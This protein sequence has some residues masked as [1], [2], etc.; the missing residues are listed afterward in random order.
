MVHQINLDVPLS[1]A[2]LLS[3]D[4][5]GQ[6]TETHSISAGLDYPGVGP[7][8]SYLKDTGRATYVSVTDKQALEALQ[9]LSRMEGIIPALEPAH[10]IYH[11]MQMARSLPKEEIVLIHMCGRGD[12]DMLTVAGA[13]GFDVGSSGV[14][15][16]AATSD[17]SSSSGAGMAPAGSSCGGGE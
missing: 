15:A 11:G 13:L 2:L 12:K 3:Q 16:A 6:I 17:G 5:N 7:Q 1:S 10:A 8:H 14:A 4:A 9:T